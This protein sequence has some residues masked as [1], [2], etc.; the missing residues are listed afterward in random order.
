MT[1]SKVVRTLLGAGL[2]SLG[3]GCLDGMVDRHPTLSRRPVS[4]PV[5]SRT[6]AVQP[7]FARRN[8]PPVLTSHED[9]GDTVFA[10]TKAPLVD[11][12]MVQ[13]ALSRQPVP[14]P[15]DPVEREVVEEKV[16]KPVIKLPPQALVPSGPSGPP[17]PIQVPRLVQHTQ[18]SDPS[19]PPPIPSVIKDED[20]PMHPPETIKLRQLHQLASAR[21]NKMDSYIVRL[22]RREQVNGQDRPEEMM[23]FKFRKSPF[24]VY[25]KWLGIEGRGREVVYVKDQFDN[26]LHTLLAAGDMPLMPAGKRMSLSPDS[27]FVRSASR[28]SINDAG[29]GYLVEAFGRAVRRVETNPKT[30]STMKYLGLLK[31]PEFDEPGDA[32]EQVIQPGEEALLPKG[33]TR[34]WLFDTDSHLPVLTITSDN[35]GHQVEYYCYD[36]LQWPVKLDNEDFN[37]DLLWRD[38]KPG[39]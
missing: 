15:P 29:F 12:T 20:A 14:P 21:V 39:K 31:R 26:K 8:P 1:L 22:R 30:A 2:L 35:T 27:I 36:R 13:N 25:F 23:T 5:V 28:H 10:A 19:A 24:S 7:T 33:G 11:D 38:R 4:Q 3:T 6:F 18:P 17:A 16:E 37:P 34:L 9:S 32:V